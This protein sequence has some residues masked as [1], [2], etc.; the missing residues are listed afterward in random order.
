MEYNRK[1]LK[2]E[3]KALNRETK[4][5]AWLVTLIFLL[6]TSLLPTLINGLVSHNIYRDLLPQAMDRMEQIMRQ[7]AEVDAFWMPEMTGGIIGGGLLATFISVLFTLFTVVLSYGYYNYSLRLFRRQKV[8]MGSIFSAFPKAGRVIGT[9]IMIA[10]FIGL[11]MFLVALA[12]GVLIGVGVTVFGELLK[13]QWLAV[14]WSVL[15]S[16]VM[17]F[18]G[19]FISFR[20]CLAPYFIL[21][22]PEMTVFDAI[23]TSKRTMKGNYIKRFVYELSFLGWEMLM[24]FIIYLVVAAGGVVTILVAGRDLLPALSGASSAQTVTIMRQLLEASFYPMLFV[25]L[26]AVLVVLPLLLWLQAYKNTADAG[27]FLAV[28]GKRSFAQLSVAA[29]EDADAPIPVDVPLSQIPAAQEPV[30]DEPQDPAE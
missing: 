10:I 18:F 9:E 14:V 8:G 24:G 17:T 6:L 7:G 25:M 21:S 16:V 27:F 2:L 1:A 29:P 20:Y 13:L 12:G 22:D 28:T 26:A 11:W 4:P 5:K 19:C 15:M 23:T 30:A 3:A